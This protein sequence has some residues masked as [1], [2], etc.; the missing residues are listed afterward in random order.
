[1]RGRR[2]VG[3]PSGA[4]REAEM[5]RARRLFCEG[6]VAEAIGRCS[7]QQ[8]GLLTGDALAAWQPTLEPPVTFDFRGHTVCKTAAWGQGPVFLQ[9]LALLVGFD[10]TT[11][12]D[13]VFVHPMA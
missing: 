2:I 12:S 13:D 9:Q 4:A 8:E 11:M 10:L 3:A 5:E 7:A 6:F 1:G